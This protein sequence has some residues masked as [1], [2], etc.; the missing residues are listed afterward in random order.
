MNTLARVAAAVVVVTVSYAAAGAQETVFNVPSGD[1]LDRGKMYGEFDATFRPDDSTAGFTPRIVVG[2]GH[3]LEVGLNVNGIALHAASQTTL[4]P[5]VKWKAYDNR[6]NGW[7]FLLGDDLFVP[8]QSRAYTAGNYFYAE[9]AKTRGARKTRATF[10]GYY[11]S[12]QVLSA[13]HRAGGQFALEQPL[14]SR[15]TLA[16]D[17]YTGHHALGYLS[18]GVVLKVTS[19]ITIYGAYQIGNSDPSRGNHQLLMEFG[20][21]VN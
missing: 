18:P 1:I 6:K 3:R 14:G 20:W 21:E 16:A 11:C 4:A 17:L 8:L 12:P 15:L 5:S 9:F 19:R 2:A 7:A 13:G 10:G